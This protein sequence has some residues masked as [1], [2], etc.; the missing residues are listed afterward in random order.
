MHDVCKCSYRSVG[1]E[2]VWIFYPLCFVNARR[3]F[4]SLQDLKG[5]FFGKLPSTIILLLVS[6][7]WA[8]AFG[9]RR[10]Y[11]WAMGTIIIP[12][13]K[14][15]QKHLG[16]KKTPNI[17]LCFLRCSCDSK[18]SEL[19]DCFCCSVAPVCVWSC[20][21]HACG[22][23]YTAGVSGVSLWLRLAAL[24]RAASAAPSSR[25]LFKRIQVTEEIR[26]R[27]GFEFMFCSVFVSVMACSVCPPSLFPSLRPFPR[28]QWTSVWVAN[29]WLGVGD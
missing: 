19:C 3:K 26:H 16:K 15:S 1:Q 4:Q 27:T 9:G 7:R 18:L 2:E 13:I 12:G 21:S 10:I 22:T 6:R 14:R 25:L 17:F 28:P 29:S 11:E 20:R 23:F 5:F 24:N 8:A